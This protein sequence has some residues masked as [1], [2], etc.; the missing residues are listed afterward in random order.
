MNP[1][2]KICK[3]EAVVRIKDWSGKPFFFCADCYGELPK[4]EHEQ[5]NIQKKV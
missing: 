1:K 2:C 3:K 5:E 4:I